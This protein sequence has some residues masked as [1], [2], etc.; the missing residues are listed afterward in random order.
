MTPEQ[1]LD[2]ADKLLTSANE[3]TTG[4]WPRLCAWLIR[5]ALEETLDRYWARV[6]PEARRCPM[7]PQLLLLPFQ[8]NQHAAELA[9]DAWFGLAGACHQHAYELAPTAAE[10]RR[11]HAIVVQLGDELEQLPLARAHPLPLAARK[12]LPFSSLSTPAPIAAA[13]TVSSFRLMS[14]PRRPHP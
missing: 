10:L 6:L 1:L 12:R 3:T 8:A 9:R 7:R 5:L 14:D 11:W 2:E 4:R 13:I